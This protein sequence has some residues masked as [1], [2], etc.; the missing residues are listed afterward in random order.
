MSKELVV[1]QELQSK[2]AYESTV[3][4][5]PP[6]LNLMQA[7]CVLTPYSFT[8]SKSNNKKLTL[9]YVCQSNVRT[10]SS[11]Y[12]TDTCLEHTSAEYIFSELNQI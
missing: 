10:V 1:Y 11:L 3:P 6:I 4:R 2:H 5:P 12:L 8:N 9:L 7:N